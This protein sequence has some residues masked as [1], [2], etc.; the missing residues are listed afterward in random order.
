MYLRLYHLAD[1][2]L[3]HD[4]ALL[5]VLLLPCQKAVER[6]LDKDDTISTRTTRKE[7]QNL[8]MLKASRMS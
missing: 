6:H 7:K 1:C 5:A 4:V 8:V 3:R 2:I